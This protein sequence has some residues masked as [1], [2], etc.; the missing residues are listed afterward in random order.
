MNLSRKSMLGTLALAATLATPLAFAQAQTDTTATD[1]SMQQS[2]TPTD[3]A[4][5]NPT[6]PATYN[7]AAAATSPVKKS[8]ADVDLNKDG[9]LTKAE[10]SAVPALGQAFDKADSNADGSLTPEEYKAYTKVK[11]K[12]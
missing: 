7:D 8:W 3:A 9:N 4:M 12:K 10:A 5:Q 2:S 6:P 1:A 11:G